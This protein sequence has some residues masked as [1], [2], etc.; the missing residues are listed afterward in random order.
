MRSIWACWKDG[1][2]GGGCEYSSTAYSDEE[3]GAMGSAV[4]DYSRYS[5]RLW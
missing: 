4:M 5:K 2:E 1:K 3:R